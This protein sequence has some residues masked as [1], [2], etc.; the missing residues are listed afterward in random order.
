MLARLSRSISRQERLSLRMTQSLRL[1]A[2]LNSYLMPKSGE[3]GSNI[4]LC[5]AMGVFDSW[6]EFAIRLSSAI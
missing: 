2:C 1:I 6:D 4:K 5:T 3:F